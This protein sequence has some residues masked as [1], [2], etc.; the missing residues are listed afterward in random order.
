MCVFGWLIGSYDKK[1]DTYENVAIIAL[2]FK[3]I[4]LNDRIYRERVKLCVFFWR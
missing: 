1:S 2:S 4:S 3:K